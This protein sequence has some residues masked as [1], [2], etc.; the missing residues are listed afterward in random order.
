MIA[1]KLLDELAGR[2]SQL[3][4]TA[5]AGELEKNVKALMTGLFS[6]L[7]LVTREEFEIQRELLSRAREQVQTLESR[8]NALEKSPRN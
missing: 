8:L 5:P 1:S 3:A 4:A 2:I 7:D 6:R